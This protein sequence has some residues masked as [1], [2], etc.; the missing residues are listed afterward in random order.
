[1]SQRQKNQS[2]QIVLTLPTGPVKRLLLETDDKL[3]QGISMLFDDDD[4]IHHKV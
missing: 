4:H 2:Q 1:M 3:I